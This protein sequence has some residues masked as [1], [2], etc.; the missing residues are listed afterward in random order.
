ML[1]RLATWIAIIPIGWITVG[2]WRLSVRRG[3]APLAG[4][5]E[6][7]ATVASP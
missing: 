1:F 2:L 3:T 5:R 6:V 7:S 4:A